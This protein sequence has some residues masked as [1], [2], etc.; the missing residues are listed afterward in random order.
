[1]NSK[2]ALVAREGVVVELTLPSGMTILARR[3]GPTQLAQWGRQKAESEFLGV[4]GFT[5][6]LL[7]YCLVK[8]RISLDPRGD[9]EVHP[10]AVPFEDLT[11]VVRWALGVEEFSAQWVM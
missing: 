4:A 5:R 6:D 10:G 7:L 9:D 2:E 11:F 1:M 8:P 3:P